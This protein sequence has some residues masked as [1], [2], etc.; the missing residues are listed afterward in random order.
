MF[1]GIIEAKGKIKEKRSLKEGISFSITHELSGLQLGGSIAL[2]GVCVTI[3]ALERNAF[4]CDI[5]PETLNKT[6]LGCYGEGDELSLERPLTLEKPLGGHFVLGHVDEVL[7]VHAIK[8]HSDFTEFSFSGLNHPE[9][10]VEKGCITIDGVSL[11]ANILELNILTCM[12]IPHTLKETHLAN[13]KVGDG[14]NVEY[15]YLAKVIAKQH[16]PSIKI[17]A[18]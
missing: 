16:A 6:Q 12:I 4:S 13:L 15:D 2:N 1:T 11:T 9:W 18:A 14:V 3:T 8:A 5:S 10:L 7:K 17:K